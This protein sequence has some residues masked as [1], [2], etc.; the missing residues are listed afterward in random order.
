MVSIAN[1]GENLYFKFP[2]GLV[3]KR[4]VLIM[5]ILLSDV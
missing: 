2:E 5:P 3:I 1:L 4:F